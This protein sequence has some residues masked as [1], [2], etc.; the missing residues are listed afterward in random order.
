MSTDMTKPLKIGG[1]FLTC[2]L[3]TFQRD[4]WMTITFVLCLVERYLWFLIIKVMRYKVMLNNQCSAK[5]YCLMMM[6]I[7]ISVNVYQFHHSDPP[8]FKDLVKL[9]DIKGP[10]PWVKQ[11]FDRFPESF[12][13]LTKSLVWHSYCNIYIYICMCTWLTC[14]KVHLKVLP[15][16]ALPSSPLMPETMLSHD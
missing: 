16:Q 13:D 15:S 10:N 8:I 7:S 5:N 14:N 3:E 11:E 6:I 4:C 12:R 1:S 2:L 9:L